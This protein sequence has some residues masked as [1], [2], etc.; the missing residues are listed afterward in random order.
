MKKVLAILLTLAAALA[1][2]G[3]N[4]TE[5]QD[6][7]SGSQPDNPYVYYY[8]GVIS[9]DGKV[10]F[11]PD[12]GKEYLILTDSS[13]QQ[14]YVLETENIY[15]TERRDEYDEPLQ[16]ACNYRLYDLRGELQKEVNLQ[17]EGAPN[18]IAR[19]ALAPDGNLD[20]SRALVNLLPGEGKYQIWDLDGNLLVEEQVFAPAEEQWE[21]DY[22]DL[23]VVGNLMQV[24]INLYVDDYSLWEQKYYFYNLSGQPL[25]LAHDY[26]YIS[27]V[28]EKSGQ[29]SADYYTADY[30]DEQGQLRT[31]L[32]D[33]NGQVLLAGFNNIYYAGNGAFVVERGFERGLMDAQGEW[34]FKESVFNELED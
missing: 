32:L 7:G 29:A 6:A 25:A 20:D 21:V 2:A 19:F 18:T 34:I 9:A 13:D 4:S 12:F 15:D 22:I 11:A 14:R 28:Y 31:D 33:R 26:G 10:Y 1:L 24:Y 16:T 17:A 27:Y 8:G 3:C 5:K 23:S 30:M